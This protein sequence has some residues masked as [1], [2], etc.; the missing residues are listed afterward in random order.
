[1]ANSRMKRSMAPRF[2]PIPRK[3]FR[4]VV[5][6]AP[7]AHPRLQSFSLLRLITDIFHLSNT[8]RE[9]RAALGKGRVMVDGVVRKDRGLSV[10]LM[11]VVQ[12]PDLDKNY[13]IV[14]TT[15]SGL[16]AIEIPKEEQGLKLCR[17]KSKTTIRGG[18]IQLGF[19]DGR[20]LIIERETDLSPGDS[21]VMDVPKQ[22]ISKTARFEKGGLVIATRGSK[23][24]LLGEIIEVKPGSFSKG[25]VV[26]VSID[27][28][29][30]DL[31]KDIL[32]LVGKEKPMVTV[33]LEPGTESK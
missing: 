4:F 18:K 3:R 29:E 24:G 20:S 19:H 9:T 25:S 23:A 22:K 33:S 14:P 17:V 11:D 13:R 21:C 6:P 12:F 2:W 27:G 28:A 26:R 15:G 32:L 16:K 5:P 8:S 7:G 30:T 1:M 31:P 10:G